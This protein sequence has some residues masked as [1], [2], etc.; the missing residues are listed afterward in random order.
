MY[1]LFEGDHIKYTFHNYYEYLEFFKNVLLPSGRGTRY[2]ISSHNT[3]TFETDV[4]L[5]VVTEK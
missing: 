2:H 4:Y 1:Y 3:K 5:T